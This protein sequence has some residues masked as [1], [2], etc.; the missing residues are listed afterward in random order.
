M[1]APREIVFDVGTLPGRDA[2]AFL[3]RP[4]V[5]PRTAA[6]VNHGNPGV[7]DYLRR[8]VECLAKEGVATAV[9][10]GDGRIE[11]RPLAEISDAERGEWR[12]EEF[13]ER[14]LAMTR[15]TV[16]LLSR[17]H[18]RVALIGFCG[19]GWQAVRLATEQLPISR[20]VACHAAVRFAAD[21]PRPDLLDYLQGV[22]VPLQ[23]HFGAADSLTPSADIAALRAQLELHGRSAQ[24]YVYAGA[25]HGFLDPEEHEDAF[26]GQAAEEATERIIRFLS[27]GSNGAD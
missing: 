21:D 7:P 24:I 10:A 4:E 9:L 5:A 20:V 26:N 2:Q 11:A 3:G 6:V 1:A 8:L 15:E 12:T 16:R 25:G 14:Y 27:R 23:F 18:G 13:A 17:E 19:G 22:R